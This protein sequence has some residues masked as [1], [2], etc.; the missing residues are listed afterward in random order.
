MKK[1]LVIGLM[2]LPFLATS[3]SRK[4]WLFH[5]DEYYQHADYH[6]ALLNY[7]NALS[8]TSG[9]QS[10][11]IPYEASTSKQRLKNTGREID[12]NRVVPVKDYIE[13]QIGMCYVQ[14]FDYKKAV[15]HFSEKKTIKSYPE[16]LY[17][18]AVAQMNVN[19]PEAAIYTFEQYIASET[20]SD[21]LL[22]SAQLSIT[23]CYYAMDET[24]TK[25]KV[26]VELADASVFNRG[27]AA[28]A[29][30]FFGSENKL[31]FTSARDG[32]VLFDPEK[33][34]SAY[35]CDLYW[36]E[37][38]SDSS[39]AAPKNFGRPLN[40]GQHDASST[41]S[42]NNVIY[43]TRWNDEDRSEQHIYLA[44]MVNLMF[45]EAFQLPESVNLPGYRSIN[46]FV[47]TD[48]KKL[49]FSSN[50][51][52]GEGGMDLWQIALDETGNVM[53]EATNV[54]RPI[55][56]ELDEVAPFFHEVSSALFFSSNGHNSIGGLDIYKAA[57]NK[58]NR[59]FDSPENMG[60]PINSS[61][62]DAYIIWDA[63]MHYGYFASDRA[64]C[65]NGHC[66]NIYTIKNEP[67]QIFLEGYAY[68]DDDGEVL[69]NTKLTFK[70]V[71]FVF[72]PFDVMTDENGFYKKELDK[73]QEIFI[74]ATKPSYFADAAS[75]NTKP[76]TSTTTLIQDFYLRPI[77]T[78]EIEIDG[79]EYDFNSSTLRSIS[80]EILDELYDFLVLN[81][82]LIVEINSHTDARGT[83]KYNLSLSERRAES[84]VTYL[85]SRGIS[86][87]RLKAVGYGESQPNYLKD[88]KKNA[89]LDENG[90]RIILAEAYINAQITEEI[91]EE[92]HQRNR[93]TS[94]KVVGETFNLQS[95]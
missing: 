6:N 38:S 52:G 89:V 54:G 10:M 2:L 51:P 46:P 91:Q 77:P 27:T 62:D 33:Q 37:M 45:Y 16:D 92:Y 30:M 41:L 24:N 78:D 71:D 84:C 40:S 11:I 28:F 20:Y 56:S 70:D 55:N 59:S 7:Q 95:K 29:P 53:G 23:G 83:D 73:N 13:H 14:T 60:I 36:T 21:S 35:L 93:R 26:S 94:F 65:E 19:Q 12:S 42:K 58:G 57:Y 63:M 4:V 82:N 74:K 81:N 88:A 64:D 79:I 32:G 18:L 44:R 9:L 80:K 86:E 15:T 76:I 67:I 61:Q 1:Y 87:K 31:M 47:T 43:Y 22:R 69:P 66:Y 90:K 39:W 50:R 85:F 49:Y 3:Q 72:D 8:D 75:V 34:E 17:H 68:N 48:A 5:A 25:K